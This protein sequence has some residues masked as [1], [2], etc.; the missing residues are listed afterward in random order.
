MAY[1]GVGEMRKAGELLRRVPEDGEVQTAL[2]L[3]YLSAGRTEMA[4]RVLTSAAKSEP[5]NATRRLNLAAALL[6]SGRRERAKEEALQA[7]ALE[8]L[9]QDAYV[10]LAE[11]EPRRA[12]YWR[13]RFVRLL[14]R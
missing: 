11:I 12:E 8:P 10:L 2:G 7:V 4:V 14:R 9:L 3:I 13:E 1:A 6:A 5:G